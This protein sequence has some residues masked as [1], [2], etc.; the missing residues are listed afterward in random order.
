MQADNFSAADDVMWRDGAKRAMP[1]TS[2]SPTTG[3]SPSASSAQPRKKAKVSRDRPSVL[4]HL[5]ESR[6]NIQ[7]SGSGSK[8]SEDKGVKGKQAW[9]HEEWQPVECCAVWGHGA[10]KLEPQR[11]TEEKARQPEQV[12]QGNL[13]VRSTTKIRTYVLLLVAGGC[14]QGPRVIPR[15]FA[16][17]CRENGHGSL[18][19]KASV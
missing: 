18:Q 7:L 10:P 3:A 17:F 1:S 9:C 12:E 19:L 14:P 4:L 13:N 15:C 8:G 16:S 6:S 5:M 2:A 11:K